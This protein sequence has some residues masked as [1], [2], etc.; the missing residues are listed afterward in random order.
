MEK[1]NNNYIRGL[2]T[3]SVGKGDGGMSREE[4]SFLID[5]STRTIQ[6]METEPYF[7]PGIRTVYRFS[8]YFNVSLDSLIKD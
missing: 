8:R 1:L 4:L 6:R 3:R 2:R 7:N 5:I